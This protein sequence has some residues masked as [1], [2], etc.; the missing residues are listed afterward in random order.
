MCWL[1]LVVGSAGWSYWVDLLEWR[2]PAMGVS[3]RGVTLVVI[4][5]EGCLAVGWDWLVVGGGVAGS[6]W[7]LFLRIVVPCW[8]RIEEDLWLSDSITSP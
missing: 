4:T 2:L 1:D 8:V 7:T 3:I 5:S 6:S